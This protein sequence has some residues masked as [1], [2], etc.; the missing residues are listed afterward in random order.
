MVKNYQYI[1]RGTILGYLEIY[2]TMEGE[3]HAIKE[4]IAKNIK[5]IFLI[6]DSDVW[7]VTSDQLADFSF[8]NQKKSVVR[9]GN[10]LNS[11]STFSKS[12]FFLKKDGFK[13]IFQN[14]T[15]IFL[16]RGTILNYKQGD[17]IFEN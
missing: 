9:S 5:T 14:A 7:K 8:F 1:D 10:I 6:T 2:P 3:V 13:M 17:F 16:S 4:K 15:P 12:G 11:N